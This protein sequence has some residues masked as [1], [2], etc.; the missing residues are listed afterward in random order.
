VM[1]LAIGIEHAH[2]VTG[3]F[4]RKQHATCISKMR[5]PALARW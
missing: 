3:Q 5:R 4:Y 2:D 1:I